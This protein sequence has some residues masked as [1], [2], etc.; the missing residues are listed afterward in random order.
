[1]RCNNALR[2]AAISVIIVGVFGVPARGQTGDQGL[3]AAIALYNQGQYDKAHQALVNIDPAQLGDEARARREEYLEKAEVAR[4]QYAKARQDKIDAD[5]ALDAGDFAKAETLYKS[6]LDNPYAPPAMKSSARLAVAVIAEKRKL[7]SDKPVTEPDDADLP[8]AAAPVAPAEPAESKPAAESAPAA[9][10][11]AKVDRRAAAEPNP[12]AAQPSEP[13]PSTAGNMVQRIRQRKQLNWQKAVAEYRALEA[14]VRKDLVE[15]NFTQAMQKAQ[16]ARQ[17]AEAAKRFAEPRSLYGDLVA[18]AE[19]LAHFVA[20]QQ[21][22]YEERQVQQQLEQV[23]QAQAQRRHQ[24]VEAKA[25]RV[26]YLMEQAKQLADQHRYDEAM[27]ALEEL[28]AIEPTDEKARFYVDVLED[29][30]SFRKQGR[31]RE[32]LAKQTRAN[33]VGVEEAKVPWYKDDGF[34]YPKNWAEIAERRR[35]LGADA[36]AASEMDRLA[37]EKLAEVIGELNFQNTT[38]ETVISQLRTINDLNMQVNWNALEFAGIDRDTEITLQLKG[39]TI[40]KALRVILD[41]AQALVGIPLSY[42]L[43]QGVLTVSTDDDLQQQLVTHLYDVH[44]LLQTRPDFYELPD[45][46]VSVGAGG[47]GG[48]GGGDVFGDVTV[49][50]PEEDPVE[51]LRT[52]IMNVV[53]PNTWQATAGGLGSLEILQGILVVTNSPTVHREVFD[54]LGRMR[55]QQAVQIAVEARFITVTAN[56]LEEMGLDLDIVLN[57]GNAGYDR[58]MAGAAPFRDPATGAVLLIPRQNS[59]LGFLPAVPAVGTPLVPT[60]TAL[61]QPYG[62]V[63]LVPGS[64][65]GAPHSGQWTPLPMV[66]NSIG[67]A[68]PAG[69]PT[70]VPGAGDIISNVVANPA[71]NVFGSFLDNL[72][73]DF[74]LRATQLDQ[75]S[76]VLTAPRVTFSNGQ[77]V[78]LIVRESIQYVS[79]LDAVVQENVGLFNPTVGSVNTGTSLWVQGSASSDR[80]YVTLTLQPIVSRLVDLSNFIPNIGSSTA[81]TG[82][83]QL[84]TI[85]V[86]SVAT[87]VTVPDGGTLLIGGQKLADETEIEAGVPILSKIPLLKR[88][89]SNRSKVKNEQV[90]LI[91][92][93]PTIIILR[94]QEELAFP[95]LST[96]GL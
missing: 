5:K 58:M 94:E 1:M 87:T 96:A 71:L 76:S 38:L 41:D 81:A 53:A 48:G 77:A 30:A 32:D 2:A 45:F 61:Q 67:L 24:Q 16:R 27:S 68:S 66:Q 51:G 20:D 90:L 6:V 7:E 89:F 59:R 69:A 29:R 39:I 52:L 72:Q 78:W 86:T 33:L 25:K 57:N 84:P 75:R 35:R 21:Q 23:R 62:Q 8:A 4:N 91:L 80:R 15:H 64:G 74:L 3:A 50:E 83:L 56:F 42:M 19:A 40:E 47:G 79:D 88:A 49:Q 92:I 17:V 36:G 54:L 43:D 63:G 95:R 46:D 9:V 26:G 11:P 82:I 12:P 28:L 14:D 65:H 93:K 22:R 10:R 55:E 34:R 70:N 60:G 73:V 37:R 13:V 44:D 18:E 31:L 85:Q